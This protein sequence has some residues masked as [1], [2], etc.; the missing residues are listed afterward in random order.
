[1]SWLDF[2]SFGLCFWL[3]SC[4][5]GVC[6]CAPA[7]FVAVRLLCLH[8]PIIVHYCALL[9][10]SSA[11]I[12]IVIRHNFLR[13]VL[14]A[15]LAAGDNLGA[16]TSSALRRC[17]LSAFCLL[18]Y[19]LLPVVSRSSAVLARSSLH[20]LATIGVRATSS[21]CCVAIGFSCF[22]AS[23]TT[24]SFG[25][26]LASPASAAVQRDIKCSAR[27]LSSRGVV[28]CLRL[29]LS[30]SGNELL[31]RLLPCLPAALCQVRVQRFAPMGL[32][33]LA[34]SAPACMHAASKPGSHNPSPACSMVCP[35]YVPRFECLFCFCCF[36]PD[37]SGAAASRTNCFRP[38]LFDVACRSALLE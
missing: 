30:R 16:S 15:A 28:V 13:L 5:P 7:V 25:R 26:K 38:L 34:A 3:S 10:M 1:M 20:C 33:P 4:F 35:G 24:L 17:I 12:I 21:L 27:A 37:R 11:R 29:A 19:A 31:R 8:L 36:V 14:V 2:G 6:R 9:C 32:F 18:G 22:R 23:P